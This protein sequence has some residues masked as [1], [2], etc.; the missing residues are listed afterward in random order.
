MFSLGLLRRVVTKPLL[1]IFFRFKQEGILRL[2]L[3]TGFWQKFS[4]KTEQYLW[5]NIFFDSS[6]VL[7]NSGPVILNE[8][9]RKALYETTSSIM[10]SQFKLFGHRVPNLEECDFASDW[11]FKKNGQIS[12]TKTINFTRKKVSPMML[13]SLGNFPDCIIW[14]LF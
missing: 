12:T 11:R 7:I 8:L 5:E 13:N 14:F 3:V 9:Q 10:S 1:V 6:T 4:Y 2:K